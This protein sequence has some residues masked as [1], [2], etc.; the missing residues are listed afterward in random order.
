MEDISKLKS[1]LRRNEDTRR[2]D[3][4]VIWWP[5]R[6]LG[7]P[8]GLK[9]LNVFCWAAFIA[10]VVVPVCISVWY[11]LRAGYG[12]DFVYFYGL[13]RLASEWPI[14]NLYNVSAQ[15][16]LFS[17]ISPLRQGYYS[18]SPY[19]PF[20]AL[21]FALF[22]WLSFRGAYVAWMVVSLLLYSTGIVST[23]KRAFSGEGLQGSLL[24]CFCLAYP[25]F[26]LFTL[27]NGQLASVA[28]CAIGL[29]AY[30]ESRGNAFW[31]GVLLSALAYKPTLLLVLVPMLILTRKFRAFCGIVTGTFTLIAASTALAGVGIWP[32]Y[33]RLVHVFR[34]LTAGQASGLP[35]H[36]KRWQFVDLNSL[37][38]AIPGG[39][40][41]LGLLILTGLATAACSW[42]AILLWKSAYGGTAVQSL[43][44]ASTLICTLLFNVYAPIYDSSIAAIAVILTLGALKDLRWNNAARWYMV[45]AFLTFAVAWKTVD[46]AEVHGIQLLTI[47]LLILMVSQLVFLR[48]LVHGR[49][50]QDMAEPH[51]RRAA[52]FRTMPAN[53]PH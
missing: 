21:F 32:E 1:S 52:N 14:V 43:V 38:Y 39:R 25:P 45:A 48:Q 8:P 19:P 28:V 20:V 3:N 27:V 51:E 22:A 17:E 37:S 10:F 16:K 7:P 26:L 18:P 23:I 30:Q 12:F 2:D 4:R 44:W 11:R 53:S 24:L 34:Q 5:E 40:S 42:L 50:P 35:G 15:L 41:G 9:Q 46:I 49:T 6:I 33:V 13:G 31:S 29:A 47:M 36:F